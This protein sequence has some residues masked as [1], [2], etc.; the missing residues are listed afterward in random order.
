MYDWTPIHKNGKS[1]FFDS[2]LSLLPGCPHLKQKQNE[3]K[4]EREK[5]IWRAKAKTKDIIL[6]S[7]CLGVAASPMA[8][9]VATVAIA[10][11]IASLVN[12]MV[13]NM[14]NNMVW[15]IC[16][17]E[18]LLYH[19][20]HTKFCQNGLG[21]LCQ[22]QGGKGFQPPLQNHLSAGQ[23]EQNTWRL[24]E[25]RSNHQYLSLYLQDCFSSCLF[26]SCFGSKGVQ[27]NQTCSWPDGRSIIDQT[28]LWHYA[29]SGLWHQAALLNIQMFQ[30]ACVCSCFLKL[31]YWY[32]VTFA[33][34]AL[35]Q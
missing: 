35:V 15:L 2:N 1:C 7:T 27:L 11:S 19:H 28:N 20:V 5:E 18:G 32:F 23:L 12:K 3:Y 14:A 31:C 22:Y 9:A 30:H 8:R 26:T 13:N 16:C 34:I 6:I 4:W 21:S 24:L 17:L 25:L 10:D 33:F 29:T